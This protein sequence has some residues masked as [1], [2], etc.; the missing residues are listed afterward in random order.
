MEQGAC[1]I[2]VDLSWVPVAPFHESFESHCLKMDDFLH[3]FCVLLFSCADTAAT[4]TARTQRSTGRKRPNP[5]ERTLAIL[6]QVRE[7]RLTLRTCN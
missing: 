5:L 2:T 4:S 6:I 1:A 3:L 7:A